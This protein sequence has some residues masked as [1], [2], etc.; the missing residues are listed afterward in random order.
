MNSRVYYGEYS[1]R[2]WINLILNGSVELPEYQR[3]FVWKDKDIERLVLS[4]KERQFVQ[5]VTIALLNNGA[6]LKGK[7]LILD[8]QQRLTSVLLAFLG[9]APDV[10]KFSEAEHT[11]SEDDSEFADEDGTLKRKA[12]KWTFK[13]LMSTDATKNTRELIRMRI[14]ADNRY[15]VLNK[16]SVDDDFYDKV[17]LGFSYIVPQTT[18]NQEIENGYAKMFR[19]MNYFGKRLSALESRRSLYYMNT[20]YRAYF[21]GKTED[22]KD[23]LCGIKI[24]ENWKAT[25]IDFVRYLAI[26]SQYSISYNLRSVLKWYSSYSS[27]ES[28]YADYVSYILN[29]DQ[30]D[31]I[32]KFNGFMMSSTFSS[33]SWQHRYD[34]LRKSIEVMKTNLG[35]IKDDAF[36]SLID[37]D[38]WLFGL[39]Y[40]VVFEGKSLVEEK[41]ALYN[42]IRAIIDSEKDTDGNYMSKNPNQLGILRTRLI[43]SIS[44]YGKYVQ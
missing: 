16:V 44:I 12:I 43:A 1:L 32:E 30:E 38:Y 23:V 39:I 24:L 36:P 2:H 3:S 31:K 28:Y 20:N 42:E 25:T 19:T 37:A 34:V 11:A 41:S 29:L 17:F 15:K 5:P 9:Y 18:D 27:R 6:N 14:Q 8:G 4:F 40:Y 33:S 21:E 7:N 22:G 26:L 13:E 35:L 10:D